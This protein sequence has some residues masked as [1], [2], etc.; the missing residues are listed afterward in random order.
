M[1]YAALNH[2]RCLKNTFLAVVLLSTVLGAL[3][4]VAPQI[5][6]PRQPL[7]IYAIPEIDKCVRSRDISSTPL[8][9]GANP[10]RFSVQLLCAFGYWHIMP[11]ST[12]VYG[13]V[14]PCLRPTSISQGGLEWGLVQGFDFFDRAAVLRLMFRFLGTAGKHG[15]PAGDGR[16]G[17]RPGWQAF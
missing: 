2:W 12:A 9:S 11:N 14:K 8:G 4:S 3:C 17:W 16:V 1:N 5:A 6:A 13:Q 15:L 10:S 7:G